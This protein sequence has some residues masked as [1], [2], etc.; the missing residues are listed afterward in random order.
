MYLGGRLKTLFRGQLKA[1]EQEL[2]TEPNKCRK[3]R[4]RKVKAWIDETKQIKED[5]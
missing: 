5:P 4:R 3:D 1:R 2:N